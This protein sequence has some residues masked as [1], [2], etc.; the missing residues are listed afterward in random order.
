M[1]YNHYNTDMFHHNFYID[2][3]DK[4]GIFQLIFQG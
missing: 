4:T 3:N 2:D 1:N